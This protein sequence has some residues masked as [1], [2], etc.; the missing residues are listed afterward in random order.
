MAPI[1][2]TQSVVD[3]TALLHL[4]LDDAVLDG[5]LN[6]EAVH[7]YRLH[8]AD[9]VCAINGLVLHGGVPERLLDDDVVGDAEVEPGVSLQRGSQ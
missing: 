6:Q 3:Y 8:L 5:A 7:A 9:A 4:H 2:V 1:A